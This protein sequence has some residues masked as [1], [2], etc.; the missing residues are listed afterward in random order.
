M[1]LSWP[2]SRSGPSGRDLRQR[3]GRREDE[4]ILLQTISYLGYSS[5]RAS[6]VLLAAGRAGDPHATNR[7]SA[8]FDWHTTA[9]P[10]KLGTC[11]NHAFSGF[12]I[13]FSTSSEVRPT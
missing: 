3:Q 6:L 10:D 1:R 7:F 5:L 8:S 2:D 12:S 4:R 11:F 13:P 9:N